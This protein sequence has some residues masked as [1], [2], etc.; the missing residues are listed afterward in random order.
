ME[1]MQKIAGSRPICTFLKRVSHGL[2]AY[3]LVRTNLYW[4]RNHT[5]L[6]VLVYPSMY[7]YIQLCMISF[8]VHISTY[9]Y[10]RVQPVADPFQ[11]GANGS[12]TRNLL[13]DF[14]RVHLCAKGTCSYA[15]EIEA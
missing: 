9:K 7:Q 8:T 15:Y 11:K 6:Y 14:R 3:V 13:H 4:D 10:I 1:G 5:Y 2:Y 12:R